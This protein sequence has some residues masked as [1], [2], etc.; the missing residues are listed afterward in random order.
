MTEVREPETAPTPELSAPFEHRS[1]RLAAVAFVRGAALLPVIGALLIVG[2]IVSPVFFTV[3]NLAGVGQQYSAL[4]MAVVGE[5]ADH[6]D[7]R[8]GPV[9]R[10][11]PTA[12]RRWSRRG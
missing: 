1:R 9:A 10:C 4:G 11:R 12:S 3:S 2:S 8:H 7:R 6:H 5:S